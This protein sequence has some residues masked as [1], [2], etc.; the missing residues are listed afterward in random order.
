MPLLKVTLTGRPNGDRAAATALKLTTL[1]NELLGKERALT[2]VAVSFVEPEHW[3][4]G[5]QA[6]NGQD[7]ASFSLHITVTAGTNTKSQIATFID[8]VFAA[9]SDALGKL[10]DESYIIVDEVPAAAW[11]YAGKTQEYRFVAG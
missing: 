3:F 7:E 5:A 2:A 9:M 11:G 4:I 1:T 6:L 10:R 8:A